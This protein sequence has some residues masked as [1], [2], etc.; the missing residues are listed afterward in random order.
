MNAEGAV[1]LESGIPTLDSQ[2]S[3][4][5]PQCGPCLFSATAYLTY[6]G[7]A[8]IVIQTP[9]YPNNAIGAG[10]DSQFQIPFGGFSHPRVESASLLHQ[11]A[12][13]Q[14]QPAHIVVPEAHFG[15][16]CGL[17]DR[18]AACPSVVGQVIFITVDQGWPII[19]VIVH[20]PR[21][22]I[23][24]I[25]RQRVAGPHHP[26]VSAPR[27]AGS[28]LKRFHGGQR[29]D[30][31]RSPERVSLPP[32]A[33]LRP[34]D[35]FLGTPCRGDQQQDSRQP[36]RVLGPAALPRRSSNRGRFSSIQF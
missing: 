18:L 32:Q 20:D 23:E 31:D 5:G 12:P 22:L 19:G 2:S 3:K 28:L 9:G 30:V 35:V 8:A 34:R 11:V 16:Q 25:R 17:E 29:L 15:R 33:T 21:K 6:V 13:D 24:G 27:V 1:G 10:R 36:L 26:R 14:G 4:V 7:V